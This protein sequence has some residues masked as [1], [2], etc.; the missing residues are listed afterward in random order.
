MTWGERLEAVR[1]RFAA[2][3]LDE[4]QRFLMISVVIGIG[5]GLL[6]VIFHSLIDLVSWL[7]LGLPAG[8]RR[9]SSWLG[10]PVGAVL[11]VWL[12]HRVFRAAKGSGV[13]QTKAALL[14]SD[15]DIPVQ[16]V[17]GKLAACS[18]SIG[19]GNAL[20]P[21]DPSLHMGAGFA[22]VLGRALKLPPHQVHLI[23]PVGAAAGIA[24][25]FNTP[26]TAV[27]FV[28]EEV[29][30]A[31][32]SATLG[33]IVLS[34]VAAVVTTRSFLGDHPLFQVPDFQIRHGSEMAVYIVMGLV[35]GLLASLFTSVIAQSKRRLSS[36]LGSRFLYTRAAAAGLIVSLV[37]IQFPQ[38]L[39]A[40][41]AAVD[42]ALHEQ[43]V[44]Q[45]LLAI[46]LLKAFV[47]A[48]CYSAGIPG[49]M[50][51]PTLFIGAMLGGGLGD[52]ASSFW[53][54]PIS[55]TS[56]FVL[57]GL[58]TF[59]AAV[60]RSPMTS[61]FMTFEVSASSSIILPV[62]VSNVIAYLVARRLR[63]TPFFDLVANLE[64]IHLPSQEEIRETERLRVSDVMAEYTPN[65]SRIR[66]KATLGWH[67]D[68]GRLPTV[69]PDQP[70]E[71]ALPLFQ[72]RAAIPVVSRRDARQV[73]GVLALQ[74]CLQRYGL[75]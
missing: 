56:A 11:S 4:T 2:V 74:D 45:S 25:A 66:W 59:F 54:V 31:W 42:G 37:G 10:P 55:N 64:G 27:L 13:V 35:S 1:A 32:N 39:G 36:A 60:F 50:F 51:A 72:G 29:L 73:E 63:P 40:G 43:Y 70:L 48:G 24:A 23:A 8:S 14:L 21:E 3:E 6:I 26:I 49:G 34:S 18:V 68:R 41:Y 75:R 30:G 17:A 61:I 38:V 15:G 20:G 28:I 47:T 7:A 19:S 58:G 52:L 71:S 33:S 65:G 69:Y 22:S 62:M 12:V 46:G 53:P 67:D 5:T 44:W 16:A 9:W 57:V